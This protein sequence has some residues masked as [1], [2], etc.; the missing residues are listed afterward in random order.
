MTSHLM[1]RYAKN[2]SS[3]EKE[4]VIDQMERIKRRVL[5][6]ASL[7]HVFNDASVV[8]LP[9]LFP[10]LHTE[11]TLIKRYS[12]IGTIIL[13]GLTVAIV[14]QPLI[15]H[16][17]KG[18]HFR[19]LLALG[20][21]IAGTSLLLMTRANSFT[22][23]ILFFIGL[24]IGTSIYH[25]VGTSWISSTF[26]G[27]SLDRAMGIQSAFGNIGVFVS[28][29]TTGILAQHFGWRVPLFLWGSL[30]FA[31]VAG[32][33]ILSRG[34]ITRPAGRCEEKAVSWRKTF[35]SITVFI[36]MILLGGI[37]WGITLNYAP[38]LLNHRFGITISQ[39]GIVLGSW[40][41]SGAVVTIFYGRISRLLG[42]MRTLAIAYAI[43]TITTFALGAGSSIPLVV[44]A[45]IMFGTAMFIT[46]P[47]VLSF[48]GSTVEPENRTAAFSLVSNLMIIGNVVFAFASGL[49]SDRFGIQIPFLLL[50]FIA[51]SVFCYLL[52]TAARWRRHP[53]GSVTEPRDT[54]RPVTD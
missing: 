11:G 16:S 37:A 15:G 4:C 17:A 44:A 54:S 28:F 5:A 26:S 36:P 31:A 13:I 21:L 45:F 33:L 35:R 30:N 19:R 38:S 22:T 39:T 52:Y 40:I 2:A 23:L 24:R 41:A 32:G 10:I 50:G 34:T 12:D 51:L 29:T 27:C 48:I 1:T 42:R 9:T 20:A 46:F 49:L 7:Y 53:E 3:R 8:T 25:P 6:T 14:L 47:A 43:I 18:R